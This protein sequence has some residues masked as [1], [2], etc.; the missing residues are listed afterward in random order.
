MGGKSGES[1]EK[2]VIGT[3]IGHIGESGM[4]SC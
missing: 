1:K 2:E 3:G 4:V